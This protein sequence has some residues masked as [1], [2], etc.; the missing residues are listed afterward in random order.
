M[1]ALGIGANTGVFSVMDAI[2]VQLIPVS[3][4]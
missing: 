1:L 3:R 4:G 2:L